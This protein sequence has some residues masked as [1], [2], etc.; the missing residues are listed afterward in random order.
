MDGLKRRL[1]KVVGQ[2]MKRVKL[3]VFR[4]AQASQLWLKITESISGGIQ[5]IRIGSISN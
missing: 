1:L 3:T 5:T 2:F 4:Q